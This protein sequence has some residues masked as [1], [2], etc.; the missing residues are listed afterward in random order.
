MLI[1][2]HFP[3]SFCSH[4]SITN[5]DVVHLLGSLASPRALDDFLDKLLYSIPVVGVDGNK[6]GLEVGCDIV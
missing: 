4:L 3:S 2:I 1:H 6:V 5:H